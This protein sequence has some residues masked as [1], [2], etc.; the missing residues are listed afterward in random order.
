M[1]ARKVIK[2]MGGA[3]DPGR[4]RPPRDR[5]HGTHHQE[6]RAENFAEVHAAVT[7]VRVVDTIVTN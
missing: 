1:V 5:S 4:E 3:M 2:G 7:G 6:R